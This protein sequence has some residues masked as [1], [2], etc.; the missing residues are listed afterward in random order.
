MAET[1]EP[2]PELPKKIVDAISDKKLVIFLGAGASRLIGCMG[3]GEL[4][5]KLVELCFNEDL[6]NFKEKEAISKIS[7]NKKLISI[8]FHILEKK[9]KN[10]F[11]TQ[12]DESLKANPSL[13]EKQNIYAELKNFRAVFVTTNADKYL[14]EQF[15]KKQVKYVLSDFNANEISRDNIYHIHGHQNDKDKIIFTVDKYIQRYRDEGF[16]KFITTIFKEYTVLFIGYGL[17]EFELFDHIVKDSEDGVIKHF[18]LM[19]FYIGEESLVDYEQ[20]YFK[21]LN[22]KIIPFAKDDKGYSQQFE[23]IKS[24][25]KQIKQTST[26]VSDT[27]DEITEGINDE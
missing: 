7:D 10:L 26:V 9:D 3:W 8:C 18:A 27:F 1:I 16:S 11:Y 23:I 22:I 21:H 13:I 2:I 6:I 12:L 19:P 5:K 24:W 25:D 20:S 15:R 4:G 14:S 17:S